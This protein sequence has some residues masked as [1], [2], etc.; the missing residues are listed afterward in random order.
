MNVKMWELDN[1][2]EDESYTVKERLVWYSFH[3]DEFFVR[4]Q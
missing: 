2:F 1:F 4:I 3:L